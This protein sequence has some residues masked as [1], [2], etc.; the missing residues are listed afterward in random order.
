MGSE[1]TRCVA[2][3]AIKPQFAFRLLTGEKQV[4]F[5]RRPTAKKLTHIVIYATQPVGAV[6]GVLELADRADGTPNS[7]WRRFSNVGGIRREDFFEY[8]AGSSKGVAYLV[9]EA[10]HCQEV[11]K[12]GRGGLPKVPPQAHQYLSSK[13]IEKLE[14]GRADN[15]TESDALDYESWL[16]RCCS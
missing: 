16:T 12:L 4:E 15:S 6:V 13:T 7:L 9:R 8:F 2:M 3:M 11:V 10:W 5:R 1:A 14:S